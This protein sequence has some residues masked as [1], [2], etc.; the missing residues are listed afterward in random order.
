MAAWWQSEAADTS[1]LLCAPLP[2]L[3]P[4]LKTVTAAALEDTPTPRTVPQALVSSV[5]VINYF[6]VYLCLDVRRRN[7]FAL[8][9]AM[10][11]SEGASPSQLYGEWVRKP[12]GT[13]TH[14]P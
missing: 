10:E 3:L 8:E 1:R 9:A 2:S 14:D 5:L 12:E 4:R 6:L 11:A 13:S 7:L